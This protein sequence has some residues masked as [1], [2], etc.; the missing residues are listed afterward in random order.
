MK[1]SFIDSKPHSFAGSHGTPIHALHRYF[2]LI[3]PVLRLIFTML[4]TQPNNR[5]LHRSVYQLLDRHE[6]AFTG[7]LKDIKSSRLAS[8]EGI[9]L[10]LS[11]WQQLL[12]GPL[13]VLHDV[14]SSQFVNLQAVVKQKR[15][16]QTIFKNLIDRL[17]SPHQ[18]VDRMEIQEDAFTRGE[19]Q[20]NDLIE[21][22][23]D[24]LRVLVLLFRQSV[25]HPFQPM[26]A[27]LIF[28][29]DKDPGIGELLSAITITGA[30]LTQ[31]LKE[32]DEL[33]LDSTRIEDALDKYLRDVPTSTPLQ[34]R[35]LRAAQI[36]QNKLDATHERLEMLSQTLELMFTIFFGHCR[37]F[38]LK[39]PNG[40]IQKTLEESVPKINQIATQL[41]S[42]QIN[43]VNKEERMHVGEFEAD[44]VESLAAQ[45][46]SL[47]KKKPQYLEWRQPNYGREAIMV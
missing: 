38:A 34:S 6:E 4:Q 21:K 15:L 43:G 46:S 12:S 24:I 5:S 17:R 25:S 10:L 9:H 26:E 47:V 45:I 36:V 3:N 23:Y 11:I 41:R 35:K 30:E 27:E 16:W 20:E 31:T 1:A 40:P 37:Y 33:Q 32:Q 18:F 19:D 22:S 42:M 8:L 28:T 13:N 7:I 39:N 2:Q 29:L 14:N 44:F